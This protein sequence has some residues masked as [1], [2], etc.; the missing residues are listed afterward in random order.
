M[1]GS[2]RGR[3][4]LLPCPADLEVKIPLGV[5]QS[6]H[7]VYLVSLHLPMVF[8]LL[9]FWLYSVFGAL[10]GISPFSMRFVVG[11]L[12]GDMIPV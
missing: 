12:K 3:A 1:S 4:I 9:L 8:V 11:L 7:W 5:S 2:V 10:P 6:V